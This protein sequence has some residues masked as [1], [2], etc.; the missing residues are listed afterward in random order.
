VHCH[1]QD[2]SFLGVCWDRSLPHRGRYFI[3]H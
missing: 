2:S 1:L 3:L